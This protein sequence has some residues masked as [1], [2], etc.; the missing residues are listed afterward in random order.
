MFIFR[1]SLGKVWRLIAMPS[2]ATLEGLAGWIL[3]S[4]GFDDDHL[5]EFTYRDQ[6]GA[7][8]RSNIPRWTRAPGSTRSPSESCR[9][10]RDSRCHSIS[11]SATTG[12][13]TSS[14]NGSSREESGNAPASSNATARGRIRSRLGR[15]K[16]VAWFRDVS[17][18]LDRQGF[19]SRHPSF[20][21]RGVRHR[22]C[23]FQDRDDGH[24]HRRC[25]ISKRGVRA[26]LGAESIAG[27]L[28]QRR[29]INLVPNV[30]LVILEAVLRSRYLRPN[31]A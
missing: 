18:E 30:A 4:V 1:V 16:R 17:L 14:W 19:A 5:Y 8:A 6:L 28:C 10:S 12:N 11:T 24:S 27:F 3:D 2:D 25:G 15:V 29:R 13:S 7:D 26:E 9:S 31:V 23:P 22:L 21:S 20:S